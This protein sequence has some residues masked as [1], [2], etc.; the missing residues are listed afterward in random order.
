[1]VLFLYSSPSWVNTPITHIS[2]SQCH[3][4]KGKGHF[5]KYC[6]NL[7]RVLLTNDGYVTNKSR[8]KSKSEKKMQN[9]VVFETGAPLCSDGGDGFD[10]MVRKVAHDDAPIVEKGQRQNVFQS[11]F[12][13]K[14]KNYKVIVDGGSYNNIING[15]LVHALGI[16]TWRQ[17]HPRYVKWLNGVGNLKI[18]HHAR[19]QFLVGSYVDK[20]VC[21]VAPVQACHLLLGRF[22]QFDHNATHHAMSNK[23]S[24]MHQGVN[25]VLEPM[26]DQALKVEQFPHMKKPKNN[27]SKTWTVLFEGRE[28]DVDQIMTKEPKSEVHARTTLKPSK[29]PKE[30]MRNIIILVEKLLMPILRE[31]AHQISSRNYPPKPN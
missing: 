4:C 5:K 23:Y 1:M 11:I 6:H 2:N 26:E 15:D 27:T 14:G 29:Q 18:T 22:W 21:D 9:I 30:D 8:E 16:S 3:T 31:M 20:M 28:D 24:F 25:H 10:L 17:P 12:K 13:I 19:G 7:K